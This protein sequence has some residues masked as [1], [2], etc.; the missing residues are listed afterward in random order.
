MTIETLYRQR[1]P[2]TAAQPF[3]ELAVVAT[4]CEVSTDEGLAVPAGTEGTIVAVYAHGEAYEVEFTAPV[5]GIATVRAAG[6]R[7][8]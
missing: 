6:L 3:E 4:L 5:V 8:S 2:Q 7:A 1:A